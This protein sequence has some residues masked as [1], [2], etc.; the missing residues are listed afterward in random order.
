[1]TVPTLPQLVVSHWEAA[2]AVDLWAAVAAGLY[3][4]GVRRV[5]GR[6]PARRTL[7]FLAGVGSI[8]VALQSGL[9]TEDDKLL[10][11]H[12]G[13]H[14]ILLFVAPLLILWGRPVVLALR[15]LPRRGRRVLGRAAQPL[16]FLGHW[17]VGLLAFYAVVIVPHIPNLYDATLRHPLLHDLEHMV[18]L[19]GGLVFLWPLFGAPAGRGALGSVG[20]LCYVI[21]SMPSCA[22][23]GA[24]LNRATTA[25]YIQYAQV[26]RPL[27]VSAVGDQQHAGAIMWVGAHLILTAIALWVLGSKLVAEERRQQVRDALEDRAGLGN[28]GEVLP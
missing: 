25:V 4:W 10:S 28:P 12:M 17:S 24:Y 26:D 22:L 7:A 13:Q 9:S 1:M 15:A 3:L 20:G 11:A 27:G 8:V 16:R 14:I 23:V 21:A 5:R 2:W 19:A 6:W 18:F